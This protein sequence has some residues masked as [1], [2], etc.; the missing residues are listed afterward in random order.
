MEVDIER[1]KTLEISSPTGVR[2]GLFPTSFPISQ[3]RYSMPRD[4]DI[5]RK[6][7]VDSPDLE[8]KR[9]FCGAIWSICHYREV[10]AVK[11]SLQ[12]KKRHKMYSKIVAR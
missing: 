2:A 3:S 7:M 11:M 10:Y 4:S 6:M 12:Q 9:V 5:L 8:S 1:A